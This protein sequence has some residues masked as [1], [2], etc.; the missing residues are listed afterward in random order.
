VLDHFL[1]SDIIFKE[2]V[3]SVS[4][5]HDID[6]LSDHEPIE[7]KLR[8]NIQCIGFQE[9]VYT[10][11]VA[12]VKASDYNIS[13]YKDIVS[14][15][16]SDIDIP[17]NAMLRCDLKCS[18]A[19]HFQQINKYV[20]D[21]TECCDFVADFVIPLTCKISKW[22]LYRRLVQARAAFARQIAVLAQS[23]AGL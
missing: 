18:N 2:S 4:A 9:R 5:L 15:K 11:C 16:L 23:V 14:R 8:L 17:T 3:C 12:W 22:W 20:V 21:N 1:V 19:L 7:L 6:N 13:N 10:P